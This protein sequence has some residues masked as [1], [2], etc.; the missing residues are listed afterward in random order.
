MSRKSS[1]AQGRAGTPHTPAQAFDFRVALRRPGVVPGEP[2]TIEALV[3]LQGPA[4]PA[5]AM[6]REP[7]TLALVIDRSASM[8]GTPLDEAKRCARTIVESLGPRDR[9][10]V[11][12]FD[13][14]VEVLAPVL[15]VHQRASLLAAIDAIAS[16][17]STD[18]HGGWQKGVHLLQ[19]AM[20]GVGVH[21]VILLSD[22]G[23][24]VGET[25]LESIASACRDA[26]RGCISTSTYGLGRNFTEDL[27]LAMAKSGRG[28]AYYGQTARDLAEPF[29][30][31]FALLTSLCARGLVLKV[32]APADVEVRLR[33]DYEPAD[34]EARAWKLPDLAYDAE[35]WAWVELRVPGNVLG[36]F[37]GEVQLPITVSAKAAGPG[38]TPLFFMTAV[39][40]LAALSADDLAT[41]P[42]D[43]RLE[44]RRDELEAGD[45]LDAV[46]SL[47]AADRWP[48]A[49]AAVEKAQARFAAHPWCASV[50][51]TMQK[52]VANRDA[53]GAK[54]AL[55][56]RDNLRRRLT[57]RDEVR[58]CLA[59]EQDAP[60][61]L[62]RK[63]EQGR[64]QP[65][66]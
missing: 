51:A 46:R 35:A 14:E 33:N 32:N 63:A 49:L 54:E 48:D 45:T 42:L 36:E 61:F 66:S 21:R 19:A 2:A 5:D 1:E 65:R 28:N 59:E 31:E 37:E 6:P 58:L 50:L 41:A 38:S 30:A 11:V 47:I 60:A 25:D 7:L 22:G 24:N 53:F 52:L 20:N 40:P 9:A 55:Y 34:G 3:S 23:A 64:G 15:G 57:A 56:A 13:D 4:R 29:Q 27:M 10:A 17:G 39:P 16:G 18:L 12:A 62:R 8:A 43:A 26:A 44:Q